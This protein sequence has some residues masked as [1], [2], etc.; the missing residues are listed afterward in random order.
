MN[1]TLSFAVAVR[2]VFGQFSFIRA[3]LVIEHHAQVVHAVRL[4][5]RKK[6]KDEEE[7]DEVEED[8][9][10][11]GGGGDGGEGGRDLVRLIERYDRANS[12][13]FTKKRNIKNRDKNGSIRN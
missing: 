9:V 12:K 7:E 11:G 10:G 1:S 3:R 6:K 2:A 13:W 8:E 4:K 5:T